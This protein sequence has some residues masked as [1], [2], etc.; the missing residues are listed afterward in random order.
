V[1][2][3]PATHLPPG[4]IDVHAHY[5]PA[6]YRTRLL[7]A[8][9]ERPDG[10]PGLPA[11]DVPTALEVMD[12]LGVATAMLSVSSP[13]VYFG[14]A[15]AARDLARLVN[16]EAARAVRDHP[17]RF[18]GFASLP[19]PDLDAA[20]VELDHALGTL[21]LD[22]VVLMTN[23]GGVYLGDP[24]FAPLFDELDRRGAVVFLHPTSPVCAESIALGYP[25]PFIEFPFDTTRAVMNLIVSNTLERCPN[26]RLIVPHAGGTLPFLAARITG[27]SRRLPGAD[28]RDQGGAEVYLRRLYYDLAGSTTPYSLASLLQLVDASRILYGSD[29]PWTPERGVR[30]LAEAFERNHLLGADDR[31]RIGHGNALQ[32]FPR[33][34]DATPS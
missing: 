14:D 16:E 11:W 24:S 6:E 1:T 17:G 30:D 22:G 5:V 4:R 9:V 19:L 27:A 15:D 32:L 34:Q 2:A 25:R 12:R 31:A 28:G 7:A 23:Y 3:T 10:M 13:G 33:L 26:L 20:L 8:G 18:G 21:G 29:W